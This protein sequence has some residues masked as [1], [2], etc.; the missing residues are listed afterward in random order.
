MATSRISRGDRAEGVEHDL[1]ALLPPDL[2]LVAA[3]D[4]HPVVVGE[5]LDAEQLGLRPVPAAGQLVAG[6]DRLD[7]GL[8]RLVGGLVGEVAGGEPVR[9]AAQPVLDR[10]VLQQRVEDVAAG[11]QPGL[12]RRGDRLRGLPTLLPVGVEEVGERLIEG[13]RLLRAGQ[14]DPDRGGEL[15]EEPAPGSGAGHR[16]LGGDPLLGGAEQVRAVAA[17]EPQVVAAEVEPL[18][19]EQLL[20]P[21][22]VDRNP[23]ELEEEQLGV[24]RR[25]PLG[26]GLQERADR[27]VGGVGGKPQVGVVERPADEIADRGELPH[28]GAQAGSVE[29]ADLALV[30]CGELRGSQIGAVE[31]RLDRC[32]GAGLG[33]LVVGDPGVGE[34][35]QV[36][37][38]S[39]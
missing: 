11:A 31:E 26:G 5:A 19:R 38:G 3:D 15:V 32:L 16:E 22:V 7:Q 33:G 13:Q 23:L 10:L 21:L 18:G 17:L 2:R 27:R 6:L 24:D 28:R 9:V 4:R 29:L 36:H 25:R 39:R 35:D 30:G 20:G 34:I 12:Q 1:A 14:L 37:R 8:D